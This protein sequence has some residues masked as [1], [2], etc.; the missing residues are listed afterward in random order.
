MK[1]VTSISDLGS[2]RAPSN[3]TEVFKEKIEFYSDE[4]VPTEVVSGRAGYERCCVLDRSQVSESKVEVGQQ[5]EKW[6]S[7]RSYW[8]PGTTT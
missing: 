5:Q 2:T 7:I 8:N 4:A 1:R 6:C 3:G